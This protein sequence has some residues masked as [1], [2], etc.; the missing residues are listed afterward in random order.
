MGDTDIVIIL[1]INRNE[2]NAQKTNQFY[3]FN[4][5][6]N[7]FLL[8]ERKHQNLITHSLISG[9][10]NGKKSKISAFNNCTRYLKT[11]DTT[12]IDKDFISMIFWPSLFIEN[13][14]A[15]LFCSVEWIPLLRFSFL[16]FFIFVVLV[17]LISFL[18]ICCDRFFFRLRPLLRFEIMKSTKEWILLIE[19]CNLFSSVR[20][21]EEGFESFFFLSSFSFLH[22]MRYSK[23]KFVFFSFPF[24][25]FERVD[26]F[27]IK[28]SA[29][30]GV[31]CDLNWMWGRGW[32]KWDIESESSKKFGSGFR[33]CL[34]EGGCMHNTPL[35]LRFKM[36]TLEQNFCRLTS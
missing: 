2:K 21:K 23:F 36:N 24:V 34:R 14:F 20:K 29:V 26:S 9:V 30:Q 12:I 19:P 13:S 28:L 17:C 5:S 6:I 25:R 32:K 22:S 11:T 16:Q 31:R 4:T 7:I 15:I 3:L 10:K 27:V 18:F 33:C 8:L 35:R 1:R